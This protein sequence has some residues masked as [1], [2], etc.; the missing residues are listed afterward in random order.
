[1]TIRLIGALLCGAALILATQVDVARAQ[2]ALVNTSHSNIHHQGSALQ[3]V[4]TTRGRV[5]PKNQKGKAGV[6][7]RYQSGGETYQSKKQA[8]PKKSQLGYPGTV[9]FD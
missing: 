3:D 5:L 2:S 8:K 9:H 6:V 4:S 7:A 1:M